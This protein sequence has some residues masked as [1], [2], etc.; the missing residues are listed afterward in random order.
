MQVVLTAVRPDNRGLADPIIQR[1]A[2]ASAHIAV[3][4]AIQEQRLRATAAVMIGNCPTCRGLAEQFGLDWHC[5][6]DSGG[7][8]DN[9]H[10]VELFDRYAP[11]EEIKRIGEG[12]HEPVCLVEGLRR[13][14]DREVELQFHRVVGLGNRARCRHANGML[15]GEPRHG[16]RTMRN[17]RVTVR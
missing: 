15:N 7:N 6:G 17:T 5:V 14:P 12:E 3:L 13:V 10:L 8:P 11:L 16:T 1:V 4:H 9:E 2:A